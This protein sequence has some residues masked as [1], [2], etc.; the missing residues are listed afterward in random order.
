[1]SRRHSR[2]ITKA[3]KPTIAPSA[4]FTAEQVGMLLALRNQQG[5][6]AAPLPR[7][8]MAMFGPGMPLMPSPI[9]PVDPVSGR[10]E[11]RIWEYPV[12][13]N[14]PGVTD[15]LVPW[16][17]LRDVSEVPVVRDCIRIRKNQVA[18]LGWDIVVSKRALQQ[19]RAND[20]DTSSIKI[21]RQLR[22]KLNPDI[23]RLLAFWEKP[24][25]EQGETFVEWAGKVLEE[26]LVLD[27]VALYPFHNKGGDRL[28]FRCLD[29]STIKV[30]LNEYGGRPQPPFPSYQ[31]VLWGF[32]RGE[33][34]ADVDNDGAI[35][36]A[37]NSDRLIYRRREVRSITPYGYSSVE[38]ALQSVDLYM[39]RLEWDKAQYTDG[40]QP[41]GWIKNTGMDTWN[42]NQL[43]SYN[44]AFNDL[45]AGQ[46]LNRMR[47][48]LLPPGMEPMESKDHPEKF[49]PDYHLH[50]IKLVAM[51]FDMTI[52]EL[53]F[54]EAKGLGSS[55]YHEG[56]ADVQERKGTNP[57]LRW[58][59]SV[60]TEIS[61]THLGMPPELEFQFLGLDSEDEQAADEVFERQV[62]SGR[63]TINES[64]E[65][66]GRA[67]FNIREADMPM[68]ETNRGI[69]FLEDA[70]KLAEGGMLIE[71]I[72][73]TS[74]E[75]E[76]EVDA[77]A[78]E[79]TEA[80]DQRVADTPAPPM[81][82][83]DTS[84]P[85]T[86]AA[87]GTPAHRS[88]RVH[89]QLQADFPQASLQWSR[90]AKWE[91]PVQVPLSR[92]DFSHADEWQLDPNKVDGAQE[93]IQAGWTKPVILIQT[94]H[95]KRLTVAD[96]HHR[97]LAYRRLNQPVMAW[98]GRVS[99]D[100]GPWDDMR[101]A[102]YSSGALKAADPDLVKTEL[103]AYYK[104]LRNGHS[105]D[106]RPFTFT[107]LNRTE[108]A[109]HEID[110]D[111]VAFAH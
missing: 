87:Y 23:A 73:Q 108:A 49:K 72:S 78:S 43:M 29:G 80:A 84:A 105:T 79:P 68:V 58:L 104:W 90:Q 89:Q 53:G 85:T 42:V 109:S 12:S 20:P 55:G 50:L 101:A 33:F 19:Y 59:Q 99:S 44:Q 2:I 62:R 36:G 34:I 83:A 86:K 52:A 75:Q 51:H 48:H 67:P 46:T 103:A 27:A 97:S 18:A 17:V 38:Q 15:R 96:G 10:P 1:M 22:E 94:P 9:D 77:A 45:Y 14:L 100:H 66:S 25:F 70:S 11:P 30:L 81:P 5:G 111:R 110:L 60:L 107:Y 31:Q 74:E 24:D 47:Y 61:R 71:P 39:R 37:Y 92:L 13:S 35:P 57:D 69:I 21:Q 106:R 4:T 41:A 54:T 7:E 28:G 98:I 65:E 93:R 26:H 91:G 102:Q 3:S 82:G 64:R 88:E 63:I 40:V 8:P 95:R 56:Q 76:S 16:R 6:V 32:P